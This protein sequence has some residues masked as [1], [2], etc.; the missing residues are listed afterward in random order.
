VLLILAIREN[1]LLPDG[2]LHA[3][4]LDVGQGDSALLVSPSGK[5]IVIDGGPDD[6]LLGHLGK[7]IP[8]FDRSIDLLVLSHPNL[9]H[10]AAFPEVLRR[11][12]VAHVLLS[13]VR[14]PLKK[15]EEMLREISDRH[16]DVILSDAKKDIDLGDGL[17]L[18]VIWPPHGLLGVPATDAE[19]NN[20]SVT[21]RAM[22]GNASILFTGDMEESQERDVL[23]S[24]A[25]I[26]STILKVAHHGSKTSTS[27][28]WLLASTP[29]R[30]VI[31]AGLNNR[32]GHPHAQ[33]IDRLRSF[34]IPYDMTAQ[35]GT[36]STAFP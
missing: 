13:G 1:A 34:G 23:A 33:I 10:L 21:L 12:S 31:S 29:N 16:I 15:Y 32:Y 18:D 20:T 36:V 19:V 30:A 2:K 9:D 11:Y 6:S 5:Q 27:T 3:Y 17:V 28:G 25:D 26:R 24:G 7:L 14:F 35:E 8:F 22:Y 4:F